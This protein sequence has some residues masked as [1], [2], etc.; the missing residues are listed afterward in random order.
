M[1]PKPLICQSCGKPLDRPSDHGTEADGTPS[2]EY[3]AVCYKHGAFSQ[4]A[5]TME[6]MIDRAAN[7]LVIQM[8]LPLAKAKEL[9]ATYMPKLRRWKQ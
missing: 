1:P 7:V 8:G 3:C 2:A 4:P 6:Q 9:V 5:A